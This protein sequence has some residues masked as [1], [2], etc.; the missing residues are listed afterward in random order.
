MMAVPGCLGGENENSNT[1][2]CVMPQG[3]TTHEANMLANNAT[4]SPTSFPE[5]VPTIS[6]I[7]SPTISPSEPPTENVQTLQPSLGPILQTSPSSTS[8][9]YTFNVSG[10][11]QFV[12]NDQGLTEPLLLCQGD[13]DSDDD[14]S[15]GL[16]GNQQRVL[17]HLSNIYL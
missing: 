3:N 6:P 10:E 16:H 11:I 15:T 14:V 4:K 12:G 1:D 13:C 17:L 9:V 8:F 5:I 7:S 2:F